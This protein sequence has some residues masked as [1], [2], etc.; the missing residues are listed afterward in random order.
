[1]HKKMQ[2]NQLDLMQQHQQPKN[3]MI[4]F[5]KAQ[6]VLTVALTLIMLFFD[7]IKAYSAL[8]GGLIASIANAWFAYKVFRISPNN[9]AVTMLASAYMGEI[10]KIVLTGAMFLSA[11]VLIKPVSAWVLLISYFVVHMTP[12]VVSVLEDKADR[13]K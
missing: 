7:V 3:Q 11:F 13:R 12:A 1:M 10:Y 6:L 8:T 2:Q 5:I 9:E 4:R